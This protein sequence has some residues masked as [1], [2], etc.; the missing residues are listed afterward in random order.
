MEKDVYELTN[1]QKNILS[2]EEFYKG[3]SINNICGTLLI[4]EPLN[5]EAFQKSICH[6]IEQNK[7]FSLKFKFENN[8]PKQYQSDCYYNIEHIN[9]NTLSDLQNYKNKIARTPFDIHDNYLFKFYIFKFHN[10]HGGFIVNIHH[11]IS[12]AWTLGLISNEIIK[13]YFN[14]INNQPLQ[15]YT[16]SYLDYINSERQYLNS[17]KFK[18]DKNFWNELFTTIPDVA[19]LPGSTEKKLSLNS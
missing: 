15:H 14:L 2:V 19:T 18:K 7:S 5:F 10:N 13:N 16:F 17:E 1:S 8:V 9:L 4:N 12:D 6:V 3:S 11:L